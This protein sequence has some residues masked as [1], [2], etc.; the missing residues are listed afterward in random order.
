MKANIW[1][2]EDIKELLRKS[3][4]AVVRGLLRIYSYQTSDE[5][6]SESTTYWNGVGFTGCDAEILTSFA[7]QY[8]RKGRL[9]FLQMRLLRKKML[10]YSVQL[11]RIANEQKTV[12]PPSRQL[13]LKL[14]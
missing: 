8:I 6:R 4:K 14:A 5:Q 2:K 9:S 11:A 10:K 1:K 3:D 12:P 13:T 7:K